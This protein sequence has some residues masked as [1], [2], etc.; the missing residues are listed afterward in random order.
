MQ[1]SIKETI[2]TDLEQV[3]RLLEKTTTKTGLRV[4]V[5]INAKDYPLKQRS[6]AEDIDE[7]RILR[8]PELP[9]LSYT[10]LPK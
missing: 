8:H 9:K 2:L 3:K 10:I 4:D 7:Q 1:R 5:R 6:M